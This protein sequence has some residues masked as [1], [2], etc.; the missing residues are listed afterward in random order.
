MIANIKA[1]YAF[2]ITAGSVTITLT[3][4][5]FNYIQGNYIDLLFNVLDYISR[6]LLCLVNNTLNQRLIRNNN[7]YGSFADRLRLKQRL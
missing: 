3:S 1:K 4:D 5:R 7:G 6:Y 2:T